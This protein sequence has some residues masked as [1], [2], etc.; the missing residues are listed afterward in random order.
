MKL[1]IENVSLSIE[2][3]SI[4]ENLNLN[5]DEHEILS[6]IGP[7]ASGKSSLLRMIAGFENINSGKIKLNNSIVDDMVTKVEPQKRNIGIIFQDLALFPH[8]NCKD[9]I[10]FGISKNCIDQK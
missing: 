3:D 10:L 2:G 5:V 6:I 9:N 7:S 4:L 8:L 1:Q